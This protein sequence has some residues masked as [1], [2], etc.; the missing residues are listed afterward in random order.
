M[1][2]FGDRHFIIRGGVLGLED[3]LVRIVIDVRPIIRRGGLRG[4]NPGWGGKT[5]KDNEQAGGL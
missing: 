4:L 1:A 3:G 5:L 2:S